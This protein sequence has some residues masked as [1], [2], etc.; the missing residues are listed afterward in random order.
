MNNDGD[1][2]ND[3]SSSFPRSVYDKQIIPQTIT[4]L[5]KRSRGCMPSAK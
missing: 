4:A 2:I 5:V 3:T 1:E